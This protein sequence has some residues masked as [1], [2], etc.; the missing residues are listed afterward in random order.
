MASHRRAW[1]RASVLV[2]ALSSC[3]GELAIAVDGGDAAPS[4]D[5]GGDETVIRANDAA[6][7]YWSQTQAEPA[8]PKSFGWSFRVTA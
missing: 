6:V 7:L 8:K 2:V 1:T 3:R 4:G 5:G